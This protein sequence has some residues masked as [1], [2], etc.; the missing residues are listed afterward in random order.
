[1]CITHK[2]WYILN[3]CQLVKTLWSG[4]RDVLHP[5]SITFYRYLRVESWQLDFIT[6]PGLLNLHRHTSTDTQQA[7]LKLLTH[8]GIEWISSCNSLWVSGSIELSLF[9]VTRCW[10]LNMLAALLLF[11][12]KV[13]VKLTF[14]I[15][16]FKAWL[17]LTGDWQVR[18]MLIRL[19]AERF[20][21]GS[22][23]IR[24][25]ANNHSHSEVSHVLAWKFT[26][27]RRYKCVMQE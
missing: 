2:H 1:M 17:T 9:D 15:Y 8:K 27:C 14:W 6:L 13:D 3:M 25:A 12:R 21:P 4:E 19:Q 18:L 11:R 24:T 26:E 20:P 10:G 23:V 22:H 5:D 16:T 7:R